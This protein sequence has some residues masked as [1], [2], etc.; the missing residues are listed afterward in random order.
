M[1]SKM[2]FLTVSSQYPEGIV[3]VGNDGKNFLNGI[4]RK[5]FC[6]HFIRKKDN[7][8]SSCVATGKVV[9]S[10]DGYSTIVNGGVE[11]IPIPREF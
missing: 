1:F 2:A 5:K 11:I 9:K 8:F 7:A 6:L 4:N 10:T 3:C